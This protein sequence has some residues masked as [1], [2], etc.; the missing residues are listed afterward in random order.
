MLSDASALRREAESQ[1]REELTDR[2]EIRVA[3]A[4]GRRRRPRRYAA[5]ANIS[6][7][8]RLINAN[9]EG[10]RQA[11][12]PAPGDGAGDEHGRA[13][14][15]VR[16]AAAAAAARSVA[17]QAI[18]LSRVSAVGRRIAAA[19]G[20]ESEL[21]RRD[22][23][24]RRPAAGPAPRAAPAVERRR[25]TPASACARRTISS[26]T[27]ELLVGAWRFAENATRARYEAI[28]K[29]NAAA[30]WEA[31]S[32][33]AGALMMLGRAQAEIRSLLEPPRLQ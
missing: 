12:R 6:Q 1:I 33:A 26:S 23:D 3:V 32:A 24:A 4:E 28:E 9:P 20:E 31:S 21:A 5:R 27:H 16:G 8:E 10:R 2:P 15:A 22:P 11:G 7:I 17:A 29:A 18:R 14:A 19:A 13:V 25:G 30:A